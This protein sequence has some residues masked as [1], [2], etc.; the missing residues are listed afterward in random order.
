[1]HVQAS[2]PRVGISGKRGIDRTHDVI[3]SA[4]VGF[5]KQ[6]QQ[7]Y[8]RLM[9]VLVSDSGKLTRDDLGSEL[10]HK[11][12]AGIGSRVFVVD[13]MHKQSIDLL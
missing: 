8:P 7:R 11:R 6:G 10:P 13:S 4:K 12:C 5:A 9:Q 2:E 3:L 1:M